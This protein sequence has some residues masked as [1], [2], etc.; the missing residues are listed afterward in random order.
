MGRAPPLA[1]SKPGDQERGS[2]LSVFTA[3]SI[4]LLLLVIP[5]LSPT[6][7]SAGC[8]PGTPGQLRLC[9]AP[10]QLHTAIGSKRPGQAPRWLSHY[11]RLTEQV[12]VDRAAYRIPLL[13]TNLVEQER[14][15]SAAKPNHYLNQQ[16]DRPTTQYSRMQV[17]RKRV[18]GRAGSRAAV[19][20]SDPG[21]SARRGNPV[22]M[23]ADR[24]PGVDV[25]NPT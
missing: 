9:P 13:N 20:A 3:V 17:L 7:A 4:Q 25:G 22:S 5:P 24:P 16:D 11:M 23:T 2:S 21:Q 19:S 6:V 12:I 10:W 1:A 14:G 15:T 8:E 18:R